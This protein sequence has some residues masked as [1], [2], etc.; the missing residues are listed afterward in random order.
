MNKWI[1]IITDWLGITDKLEITD[2]FRIEIECDNYIE[3]HAADY[4]DALAGAYMLRAHCRAAV[5]KGETAQADH[6][7]AMSMLTGVSGEDMLEIGS[8]AIN[9]SLPNEYCAGL[10]CRA[11]ELLSAENGS[12][13]LLADACN[14]EGLCYYKMEASVDKEIECFEKAGALMAQIEAPDDEELLLSSLIMSNL[15]EC[16]ARRGEPDEAIQRYL[17]ALEM[18]DSRK[19]VTSVSADHY[20]YVMRDLSEVSRLKEE[21]VQANTCLSKA[22]KSL[23]K[24]PDGESEQV[25]AQLA[26]CYNSRG[27]LRFRMGD[28]EGEIQDCK[29]ALKYRSRIK[30]DHLGTA[31]VYTNI[32]EAYE[33]LGNL[34]KAAENHSYAAEELRLI[35]EE[36]PLVTAL[37]AFRLFAEARCLRQM[38]E[39]SSA[40]SVFKESA[41]LFGKINREEVEDLPYGE[42]TER[43]A[44]CRFALAQTAREE[45]NHNYHLAIT[46][47]SL[48]INLLNSLPATRTRLLVLSL[49]HTSLGELYEL[50]DEHEIAMYQFT[51]A[52][53]LHAQASELPADSSADIEEYGD[54]EDDEWAYSTQDFPQ[55]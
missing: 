32:A 19:T 33:H 53:R 24:H 11:V 37:L 13:R 48:G 10:M 31:T 9:Y 45:E 43:E 8:D 27:T 16:Y 36:T 7:Q 23:E 5:G 4:D 26:S 34:R 6:E 18:H 21:T 12:V 52:D 17:N 29:T 46:E 42:L 54:D 44:V 55:A 28:Y 2:F 25:L 30:A 3:A 39:L 15:A 35:T 1:K 14:K 49:M 41:E 38:C 20:A 22:I 47:L 51:M 40:L 50:F